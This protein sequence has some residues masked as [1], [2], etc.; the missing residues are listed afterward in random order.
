MLQDMGRYPIQAFKS[1]PDMGRYPILELDAR[2]SIP[3]NLSTGNMT[4]SFLFSRDND[5]LPL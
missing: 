4:I 2:V 1:L 3:A 5:L